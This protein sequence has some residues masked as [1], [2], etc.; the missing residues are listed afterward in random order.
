[1]V[2]DLILLAV[3]VPVYAIFIAAE[4]ILSNIHKTETYT[5]K[6]TLTNFLCTGLNL[7]FD[8]L[9]RVATIGVLAFFFGFRLME[10][11]S[12]IAYWL[13]LFLGLDLF[14]YLLH[15]S[16]H[17]CRLFW[18]V[19]VTH[20]SSEKFNLTVAIRSSVFQPLYRFVYFIPL[21]IAGFNPLDIVF[22]YAV[23]QTYGFFVHTEKVSK[24]GFLEWFMV[25]PSHHRVHHAKNPL[26]LDKNMGMV[27]IIWD[28]IFGTFQE[29]TEKAEYGLTT[30]LRTGSPGEVIFGE[31]KKLFQD[32][33]W[34]GS[35][36]KRCKILFYPPG[37]SEDKST[38]TSSEIREKMALVKG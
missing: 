16:D 38:L 11:S 14:Y 29:E 28:R 24:L 10:I 7:G 37:W 21:A 19:H 33:Y 26:Y 8:V 5:I 36:K 27:L 25:T 17:Y 22:M 12:P 35:W 2:R 6:D 20:H 32:L 9:M 13:L 31:W 23:C 18:A 34:A 15:L 30:P 3:E 1:M 4:I